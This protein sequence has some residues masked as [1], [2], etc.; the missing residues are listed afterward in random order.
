MIDVWD[1][2]ALTCH[3]MTHA[4]VRHDRRRGGATGRGRAARCRGKSSLTLTS[5]LLLPFTSYTYP[6]HPVKD[7][8][9]YGTVRTPNCLNVMSCLFYDCPQKRKLS[10]ECSISLN[11]DFFVTGKRSSKT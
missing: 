6:A 4:C 10:T 9:N 8:N 5:L 3:G 7:D 11:R 2:F 1:L